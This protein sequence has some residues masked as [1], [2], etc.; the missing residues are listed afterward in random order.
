MGDF[1]LTAGLMSMGISI[2]LALFIAPG[3]VLALVWIQ[4]LLLA[5]DKERIRQRHLI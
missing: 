4:S 1:F 2:G 3:I 5:V